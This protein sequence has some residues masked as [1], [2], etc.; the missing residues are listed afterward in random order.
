MLSECELRV[1]RGCLEIGDRMAGGRSELLHLVGV[2]ERGGAG[3]G[4]FGGGARGI[5]RRIW[6]KLA[7]LLEQ[8]KHGSK[9]PT[10]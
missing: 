9:A 10:A 7:T 5:G 8:V 6:R 4:A 1:A 3:S 2:G